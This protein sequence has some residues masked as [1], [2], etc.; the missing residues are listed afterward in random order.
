ML[1][2][3]QRNKYS[4]FTGLAAIFTHTQQPTTDKVQFR[5][6]KAHH[7]RGKKRQMITITVHSTNQ[8][9]DCWSENYLWNNLP[10]FSHLYKPISLI[11]T[12]ALSPVHAK[13]WE[14]CYSIITS[15]IALIGLPCSEVTSKS[16]RVPSLGNVRLECPSSV[17][18]FPAS[19]C[20]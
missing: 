12:I 16:S 17:F 13:S 18:H 15:Q 14:L 7:A 1:P 8:T 19:S 3:G 11:L 4:L 10:I 9:V 5:F 2:T 20:A 6:C